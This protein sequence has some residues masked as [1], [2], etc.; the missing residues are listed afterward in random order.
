MTNRD[1]YCLEKFNIKIPLKNNFPNNRGKILAGEI[2]GRAEGSVSG[3][4][5]GGGERPRD[6]RFRES[7]RSPFQKIIQKLLNIIKTNNPV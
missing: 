7:R 1:N 6:S 2:R 4:E 5:G 3:G